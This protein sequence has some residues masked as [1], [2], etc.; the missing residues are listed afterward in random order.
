MISPLLSTA[1]KPRRLKVPHDGQTNHIAPSSLG[2]SSPGA[3]HARPV[4]GRQRSS[5]TPIRLANLSRK[6]VRLQLECGWKA[7]LSR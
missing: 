6:R 4:S 7:P 3:L 1:N 5:H 2:A